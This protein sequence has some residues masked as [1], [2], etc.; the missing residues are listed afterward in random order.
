MSLLTPS[1]LGEIGSVETICSE[2]VP[3]SSAGLPKVRQTP[4]G[5]CVFSHVPRSLLTEETSL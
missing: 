1:L 3:D 4:L 2:R 5:K